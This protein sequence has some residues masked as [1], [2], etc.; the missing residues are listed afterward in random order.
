MNKDL[1]VQFDPN[2][3]ISTGVAETPTPLK[4]GALGV[5]DRD[6]RIVARKTYK[7]RAQLNNQFL[8]MRND[9]KELSNHVGRLA[10]LQRVQKRKLVARQAFLKGK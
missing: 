1:P 5:N 6:P 9:I 2:E 3:A 4:G 7:S 10:E 8:S